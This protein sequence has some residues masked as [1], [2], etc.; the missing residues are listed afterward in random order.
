MSDNYYIVQLKLAT[1]KNDIKALEK[2]F[3]YAEIIYNQVIK[4]CRRQYNKL[5]RDKR[6]PLVSGKERTDLIRAYGLTKYQL[7]SYSKVIGKKY[8][9]YLD[10]KVVQCISKRV[11][12]SVDSVLYGNGKYI[13]FKKYGDLDTIETDTNFNKLKYENGILI[14]NDLK[15]KVRNNSLNN[16]YIRE[17]LNNTVKYC[18]I[19]RLPFYTGYHYYVQ[20]V[21][22]GYPPSKGREIGKGDVGIDIGTSTIALSAKDTV[23]LEELAPLNNK[24]VKEI[25]YLQQKMDRSKRSLNKDNYNTDGTIKKGK[26]KWVFSK[27]YRKVRMRLKTL[28]RKRSAYIKQCHEVLSNKIITLGNNFYIEDMNFSALQ[29]KAKKS[30]VVNGKNTKRKRFGASLQKRAPSLLVSIIDRK[31]KYFNE[32]INKVNTKTFKAS[33]YNHI[34]DTYIPKKLYDRSTIIDNNWIQR[35]LYSAFLLMNSKEDLLTTDRDKCLKTF[36]TFLILHNNLINEIKQ[37][38]INRPSCFGF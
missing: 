14:F 38:G 2:R 24:Y 9:R 15:I 10:S 31:L 11:Y 35:D 17:S 23:I 1:N 19:K 16:P 3:H 36:N 25:K 30:K 26:L 12:K 32:T 28:F 5:I 8:K 20:L 4:Y 33:Q 37:S 21:I 29:K 27:S 18:R 13:H 7:F 22:K 6:Y 34:E